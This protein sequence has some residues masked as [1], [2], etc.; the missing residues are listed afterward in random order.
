MRVLM[1]SEDMAAMVAFATFVSG[2]KAVWIR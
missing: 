1:A 2:R